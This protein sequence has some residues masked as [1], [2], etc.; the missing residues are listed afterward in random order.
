M[1]GDQADARPLPPQDSTS[2]LRGIR[3]H[4]LRIQAAKIHALN[5]A[6][7]VILSYISILNVSLDLYLRMKLCPL[8]FVRVI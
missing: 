4:E 1:D 7:T 3:T 6:A 5:T 2:A 8:I